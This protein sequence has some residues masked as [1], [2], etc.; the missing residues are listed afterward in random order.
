MTADAIVIGAGHNGLVAANLLADAG[1]SVAVLETNDRIGG[2]VHSDTSLHDE[3]VTDWFSAFYPLAAASPVLSS[4]HL[5]DYGL[6][7]THAPAPLAHILP[8]DTCALLSRDVDETAESLARF[9]PGDADEWRRLVAEFD[10]VRKPLLNAIFDPFPPVRAGVG[11]A[12]SLGV[13][14]GL[15]FARFA[16]QSVR[17]FTEE[18]F[19]GAGARLLLAGN[20]LHT[21]L[22][23]E[24]AGSAVYGWLLAMLGQR[25][26]F[27]VPEGG[28]GKLVQALANRL[29]AKGGSI[30]LNCPVE[31]VDVQ[32]GRARGVVTAAGLRRADAV[33]ADVDAPQLYGRLVEARHLPARLL[34]DLTNFHWDSP[35]MKLDWALSAP[36]GWTAPDARRAGTVHLG[37]DMDGLTRYASGLATRTMPEH[38]FVL[39]GQMT[40]A[41]GSRS[42]AGTE[43]AWA[44]THLPPQREFDDAEIE[45]QAERVELAIERHAPGFRD[46]IVARRLQSPTGLHAA[47]ANLV[48]GAVGGGTSNIYQQLVFRPVPGLARAETPVDGLYLASA[49]AHPGGGVHGG[50]GSNA[51]RAALLRAG[52]LGGV[53][54]RGLDAAFGQIYR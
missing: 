40:L 45:A 51:A 4:L 48:D 49:S 50:P 12:R 15:R 17:R 7:W 22:A 39:L 25:V 33:L 8:D 35:T 27:P 6:R 1:W 24:A 53:W 41:D 36:I 29:R 9:A 47:D 28:S 13:A 26:G 21:D 14:S 43:S 42:P 2:A 31:R 37:V 44:Y 30:E 16:V 23:P 3:Y 5:E 10:E 54:R 20:A 19:D 11:L 52:R 18:R 38:P 32:G 34:D 46:A